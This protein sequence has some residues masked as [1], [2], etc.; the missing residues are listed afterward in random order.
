MSKIVEM[1]KEADVLSLTRCILV[2]SWLFWVIVTTY[3]VVCGKTWG[4]YSDFTLVTGT[5]PIAQLVNKYINSKWN[6]KQG[7]LGK[8]TFV[9][10]VTT[11]G[12]NSENV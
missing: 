5:A 7:E 2:A 3:L 1:L 6:T 10:E 8:I 9:E 11:R 4:N 12:S